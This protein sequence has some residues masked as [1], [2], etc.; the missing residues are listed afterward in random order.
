MAELGVVDPVSAGL[1]Q[2]GVAGVQVQGS[3]G[4][5][6]GASLAQRATPRQAAPNVTVRRGVISVSFSPKP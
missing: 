4:L 2:Q 1:A 5:A 6:G 3:T